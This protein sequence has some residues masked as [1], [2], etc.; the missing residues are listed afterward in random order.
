MSVKAESNAALM[1]PVALDKRDVR[2]FQDELERRLSAS[3]EELELDCSLLEHASSTHVNTLWEARRRC[4]EVG[5]KMKLT[6]VTYGL[7]RVLTVLDLYDLFITERDGIEAAGRGGRPALE[8]VPAP[9]FSLDVKPTVQGIDEAMGGLHDYLMWLNNGELFAFDLET[10]F[11]EVATNIRLHGEL[12]EDE[13]IEFQAFP[14]NGSFYLR[15][16]DPGPYFDPTSRNSD[17]DPEEVIRGR[18][19]RGFGIVMINRL[20]DA[21]SY[22]REDDSFNVL[23]LAKRI[24]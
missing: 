5:V 9:V 17:L 2:S 19:R 6:S 7:E 14:R 12:A 21:I 4:E 22:E 11:Y 1:V 16:K 20:V 15:F 18:Q 23:N 10:V 3:P 13:C 8:Y 24:Y